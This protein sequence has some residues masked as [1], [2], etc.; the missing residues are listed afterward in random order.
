MEKSRVSA[1][2]RDKIPRAFPPS[3]FRVLCRSSLFTSG[4]SYPRSLGPFAPLVE[5][6]GTCI[7]LQGQQCRH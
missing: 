7:D 4:K 3:T 2:R 6:A 5:E 1:N